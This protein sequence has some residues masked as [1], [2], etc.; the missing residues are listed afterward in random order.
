M[1]KV[2]AGPSEAGFTLLEV[3]VALALLGLLLAG[4]FGVLAAGMKASQAAT[5]YTGAV[6]EAERILNDVLANGMATDR[7]DGVSEQGY[8]WRA[9]H[10]RELSG[11]SEGPAQLL[12][13]QVS[14]WWPSSRGMQQ[15]D[16]ATFIMTE[17]QPL[18]T[19]GGRGGRQ[20]AEPKRQGR[21]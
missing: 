6:L 19:D 11:N 10:I 9:E 16:L 17:N 2:Q 15:L 5:N 7:K 13:V 12:R 4:A 21:L 3:I 14:V 20:I 8:R 18:P 1:T